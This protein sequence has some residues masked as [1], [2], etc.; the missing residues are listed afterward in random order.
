MQ[1]DVA[2]ARPTCS[3]R[4]K[5]SSSST[6][7]SGSPVMRTSKRPRRQSCPGREW[8][9]RPARRVIQI[10]FAFR[11]RRAP[12]RCHGGESGRAGKAGR[13][14]RNRARVPDVRAN[15]AK[16]RWQRRHETAPVLRQGCVRERRRTIQENGGAVDAENFAR[17]NRNCFNIASASSE[18]VRMDEK[19]LSTSAFVTR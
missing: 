16:G 8:A 13:R 18:W 1:F 15:P 14:C 11:R 9:R 6:L 5:M 12:R 4:W 19:S 17:N 7:T 3:S 10:P 2:E